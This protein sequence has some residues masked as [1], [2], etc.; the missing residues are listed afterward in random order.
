MNRNISTIRLIMA[1]IC[2]CITTTNLMI[3]SISLEAM[4]MC[5]GGRLLS[6]SSG[7][8]SMVARTAFFRSSGRMYS[9][10]TGNKRSL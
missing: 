3:K 6:S 4:V 5:M 1:M 7:C 2:N 9:K 8:D 10:G